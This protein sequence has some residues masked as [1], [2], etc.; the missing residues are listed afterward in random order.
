MSDIPETIT[1]AMASAFI[2]AEAA[3]HTDGTIDP[4]LFMYSPHS[5]A[6]AFVPTAW[7][8]PGQR[9]FVMMLARAVGVA[10]RANRALWVTEAM[11]S[12]IKAADAKGD[13]PLETI[14]EPPSDSIESIFVAGC[15]RT[16]G[17][18]IDCAVTAKKI[19]RSEAGV[20]QGLEDLQKPITEPRTWIR[21]LL[22][23]VDVTPD[24]AEQAKG[25]LAGMEITEEDYILD[26]P[27][28][29]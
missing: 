17:Q 8:G 4:V 3:M 22:L 16:D 10:H 1:N 13:E 25:H 19:I 6:V 14:E 7:D 24:I 29:Q 27:T 28:T 12:R 15:W 18:S 11:L 20:F 5:D 2:E 26:R 23:P 9:K 21:T